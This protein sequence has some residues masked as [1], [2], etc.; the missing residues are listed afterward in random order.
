METLPYN[1]VEIRKGRNIAVYYHTQ[2]KSDITLIFFHGSMAH[3][4]QFVELINHF[5]RSYNVC[6]YDALGCGSSVLYIFICLHCSYEHIQ[7]HIV[8]SYYFDDNRTNQETTILLQ[9]KFILLTIY[10]LMHSKFSR[11][12]ERKEI[13]WSVIALVNLHF[14]NCLIWCYLQHSL[15]IWPR[16]FSNCKN[17]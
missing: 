13:S 16:Y 10:M 12:M 2:S 15:T 9:M 3:M 11:D 8:I 14:S 6:A 1:T 7:R 4:N 5:K 17:M